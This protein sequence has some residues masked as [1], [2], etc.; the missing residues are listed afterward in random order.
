MPIFH[1]KSV[2]LVEDDELVSLIFNNVF[3]GQDFAILDTTITVSE[4]I[5]KVQMLM[6]DFIFLDMK[7]GED[8][9][10]GMKVLRE[11]N[12]LSTAL[13]ASG[14]SVL[15][16]RVIIMSSSIPLQ[17]I[18]REAN[19]LGAISFLDKPNLFNEAYVLRIGQQVGI[20]LL[21]RKTGTARH[22]WPP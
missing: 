3:T 18:L 5:S 6:Y 21:P 13:H 10:G 8:R 20:P 22:R 4:A 7:L 17:E 12:R 16:S 9:H 15:D 1:Q 11:L 19:E 14:S 2:L